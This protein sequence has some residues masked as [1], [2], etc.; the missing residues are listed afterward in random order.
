MHKYY[1]F[2]LLFFSL[3]AAIGLFLRWQFIHPTPGIRYTWFLHGHSHI[4]FLGWILNVLYLSFVEFHFPEK[5]QA[6]CL[7]FFKVLLALVMAMMI[8]FPLQG[9]GTYSI[10]FSTIHTVAVMIFIVIL[11]KRSK[12]NVAISV[13]MARIA[14]VFFFISTAGPFSLGYL[15]ANGMGQTVWYN[16]SIYYYLHFQYNGF[17][18]FG[19]LSLFYH[20]LEHKSISFDTGKARQ[21]SLWMAIACVP[22]YAL[23]VLFAKPGMLFNAI[24]AAAALLQLFALFLFLRQLKS[25]RREIALKFNATVLSLMIV[26]LFA[27]VLK[28]FLQLFSAHPDIAQLAYQ[29]RPVVIAYLHLVMVGTATFFLL[30]WY[31]ER[32]LVKESISKLALTLLLAGFLGSE[33]C[34]VVSPWWS[35]IAPGGTSSAP[36]LFVF[37]GLMFTGSMFFYLAFLLKGPPS[38]SRPCSASVQPGTGK[39]PAQR[40]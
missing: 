35:S 16:F 27:L 17:F 5:D 19:I 31:L 22:A 20:L 11:L 36:A 37:S 33:T 12:K 39:S 38:G 4:M 15:M 40:N 7:K 6:A 2:P 26:A 23:S 1:G 9:Y 34:L 28:S 30:A 25:I 13:W 10:I 8:S 24:G 21:F 14:W 18:L 32:G 29:L 3:A